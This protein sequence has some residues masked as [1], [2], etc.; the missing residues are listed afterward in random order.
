VSDPKKVT[1]RLAAARAGL[2]RGLAVLPLWGVE[3]G[4]CACGNANCDH[5]GK[6]PLGKLG[7]KGYKSATKDPEQVERWWA[8]YPRANVGIATGRVSSIVILDVDVRHGGQESLTALEKKHGKLIETYRVRTGRDEKK[9][10]G[11]HHYFTYSD[12]LVKLLKK[13]TRSPADKPN[14][15]DVLAD[16][17][18]VVGPGSDHVSGTRYE[19]ESSPLAAFEPHAFRPPKGEPTEEKPVPAA[20]RSRAKRVL[21]KRCRVLAASEE[22][23]RNT[24]EYESGFEVGTHVGAGALDH[25]DALERLFAAT[26]EMAS[27]RPERESR[28]TLERG[29]RDGRKH[30]FTELSAPAYAERA[31]RICWLKKTKDAEIWVPLC[32]FAAAIVEELL[33][34]DGSGELARVFSLE[35]RTASGRP[36]AL[37]KV[38]AP[39]FRALGWVDNAWGREAVVDPGF[40]LERR[41]PAAIK[42]LSPDV[43][44]RRVYVHTGWREIDGRPVFLTAG[45]AIGA[46]GPVAGVEVDL[47]AD[48]AGYRLPRTIEDPAAAMGASLDLLDP[49][50]G[51]PGVATALWAAAFRAPLATALPID[52]GLHVLGPTGTL[53]TT[54][55]ALFLCHFG[56][57]DLAHLPANWSSTA[58][59]LERQAFLIKDAPLLVDDYVPTALQQRE[60]ETKFNQVV[61]G[62]ANQ[63]GRGRLRRDASA[64][65]TYRAR[66]IVIS[67]G[68]SYPPGQSL[69]ARALL[70]ELRPGQVDLARLTTLQEKRDRLPHAMAAYLAWLAP[71]LGTVGKELRT[72]FEERRR[73]ATREGQHPRI[74]G[75]IAQLWL[76]VEWALRFAVAVGAVTRVTAD[77][78]GARAWAALLE[79][80]RDQ[81]RAVEG[82]RPTRRFLDL[83]F[84]LCAQGRAAL[85]PPGADGGGLRGPVL[86]GWEDAGNFYLMPNAAF[87]LVARACRDAG[88]PFATRQKMLWRDL[89]QE[90]LLSQVEKNGRLTITKRLGGRVVRVLALDRG[91]VERHLEI[92]LPV[93]SP[94]SET[95]LYDEEEEAR[96]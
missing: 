24:N 53:K 77:E 7:I 55:A 4:R 61:R 69:L 27:P 15:L 50:L 28:E 42:E 95:S 57:F 45:S 72:V 60:Y 31:G 70:L 1:G 6:H 71:Q 89:Q 8:A 11:K 44:A 92:E 30:L 79:A 84:S 12:E 86:V 59:Y 82:E 46:A 35:G 62:Q 37:V 66:G 81:A 23:A 40:G 93:R 68:E 34:D 73:R 25:R 49:A 76:G 3:A 14:G 85:V 38:P 18:Y 5:P 20:A 33:Q 56:R 47:G 43:P 75:G 80:G 13:L 39:Q 83:V 19:V 54:L 94:R 58:N 36:L 29:L 87:E 21:A 91:R 2:E 16:G 9:R 90:G 26:R 10:R 52:L 78:H 67:T 22:G 74:P 64:R 88:E 63:Q 65:P 96:R 32:N 51:A 41:L 48:L 17:G